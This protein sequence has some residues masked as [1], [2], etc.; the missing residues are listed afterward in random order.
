MRVLRT[1]E[2][3]RVFILDSSDEGHIHFSLVASLS[4]RAFR[5]QNPYLFVDCSIENGIE[6]ENSDIRFHNS[7]HLSKQVSN[8]FTVTGWA[9]K[10]LIR[11]GRC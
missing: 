6:V 7:S 2:G 5:I 10:A 8:L 11:D 3:A 1:M 9:G 4:K